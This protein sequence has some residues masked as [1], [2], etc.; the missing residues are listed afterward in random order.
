MPE[1]AN[2]F[3]LR[4]LFSWL[5]FS[6]LFT[7]SFSTTHNL[8][9]KY[10]CNQFNNV[11]LSTHF[12]VSKAKIFHLLPFF[13]PFWTFAP[14]FAAF[15]VQRSLLQEADHS[16]DKITGHRHFPN[17]VQN[18]IRMPNMPWGGGI[19]LV[20]RIEALLENWFNNFIFLMALSPP[21]PCTSA[22]AHSHEIEC[23]HRR[24]MFR[25]LICSAQCSLCSRRSSHSL[26]PL[27][28]T[29]RE[30]FAPTPSSLYRHNFGTSASVERCRR[31]WRRETGRKW[32]GNWQNKW[33]W[34][35]LP[36]LE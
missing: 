9:I 31:I 35:W 32:L 11:W 5:F 15:Q 12:L 34:I 19:E 18:E 8:N 13:L 30:N 25:R 26:A 2:L 28:G 17:I 22:T 1:N 20:E 6:K 3:A 4:K 27:V 33:Y 14:T 7:N 10:K 21:L 23:S 16:N 29:M 36:I 24:N